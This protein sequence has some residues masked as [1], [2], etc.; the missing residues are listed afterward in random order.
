MYAL[1]LNIATGATLWE[2]LFDT[3]EKGSA[4]IP[5]GIVCNLGATESGISF[6]FLPF[7]VTLR[8]INTNSLGKTPGS[9][10]AGKFGS[11]EEGD[12]E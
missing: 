4:K 10:K 3:A 1:E 2:S 7:A 5:I 6:V 12:S 8:I 11:L 9:G